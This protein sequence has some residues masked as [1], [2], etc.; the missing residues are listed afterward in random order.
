MKNIVRVGSGKY[1]EVYLFVELLDGRLSISGVEGPRYDGNARGGCGQCID[2]LDGLFDL[3][4]GVTDAWIAQ[5][6]MIWKR[7]HLNDMRAGVPVQEDFIR[8]LKA[9]GWKYDYTD[10]CQKLKAANLFEVDGYRYGYAWVKEA[11]PQYVI[12]W[13]YKLPN[14]AREVIPKAWAK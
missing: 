1:G 6:K 4:P 14:D 3:S 12:D 13:A 8:E 7:W 11:L 2:A 10:A 5:T 9:S